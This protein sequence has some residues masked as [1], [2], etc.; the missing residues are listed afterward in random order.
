MFPC[1]QPLS[2]THCCVGIVL[3]TAA[4]TKGIALQATEGHREPPQSF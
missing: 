3:L 2:P 4:Y 1:P